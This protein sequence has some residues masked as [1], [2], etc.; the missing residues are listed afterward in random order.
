VA[1]AGFNDVFAAGLGCDLAGAYL[2]AQ[3]L[4]TSPTDAANRTAMSQNSF[5]SWNVRAAE[6]RADGSAGVIALCTGF[7]LQA[8]GYVLQ[9]GGVSSHTKGP[10]AAAVGIVCLAAG[11]ATAFAFARVTRWPWTRSYL[12]ELAHY[13]YGGRQDAPDGQELFRYARILGRDQPGEYGDNDGNYAEH[14]R[15]VWNVERVRSRYPAPD[16]STENGE[17]PAD[18]QSGGSI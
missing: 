4:L 10:S 2:L 8:L 14:A 12:A 1:I 13:D 6:D 18:D 11:L 16:S 7:L 5:A 15:R 17:P 3:G 9:I